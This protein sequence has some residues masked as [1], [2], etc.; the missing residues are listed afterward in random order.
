MVVLCIINKY[1]CNKKFVLIFFLKI[2]EIGDF[3]STGR[4][5]CGKEINEYDRCID[6]SRCNM[7]IINVDGILF[8]FA[9]G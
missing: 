5:P 3:T 7:F 9:V 6:V 4:A 2:R 1:P 8:L